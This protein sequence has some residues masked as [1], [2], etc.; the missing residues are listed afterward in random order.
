MAYKAPPLGGA[1][2][3]YEYKVQVDNY[4]C[5]EDVACTHDDLNDSLGNLSEGVLLH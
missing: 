3:V 1:F 4:F 5:F 2:F